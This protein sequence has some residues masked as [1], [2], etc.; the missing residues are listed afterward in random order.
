MVA[1]GRFRQAFDIG[2]IFLFFYGLVF[3]GF[4]IPASKLVWGYLFLVLSKRSLLQHALKNQMLKYCFWVWVIF[5]LHYVLMMIFTD[6]YYT[7]FLRN[8]LWFFVEGVFGAFMLYMYLSKRYETKKMLSMAFVAI[9]IQSIFVVLTFISVPLRDFINTILTITD[10]RGFSSYRMKGFSNFGG[11]G[12]S[13]LQMIGVVYGGVLFLTERVNKRR[14]SLTMMGIFV[15]TVAQ[16]FIGRTGLAAS[17]FLMIIIFLQQAKN[18]KSMLSLIGQVGIGLISIVSLYV[19]LVNVIPDNLK[20]TF[21]DRVIYRSMEVIENYEH[22]GDVSTSSTDHLQTMY[23]LPETEIGILLGTAQW[24][25]NRGNR[26]YVGRMVESDVGYVR[27]IFAVGVIISTVFYSMYLKY[28]RDLLNTEIA[29]YLNILLWCLLFIFIAG[30]LKEPFLVRPTGI[31]K[32][33]F[34][35]YFVF[36]GRGNLDMGRRV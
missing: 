17:I 23:F 14:K 19:V 35:L 9:V 1:T 18:K 21:N 3:N 36:L 27:I 13:Y 6:N 2:L 16:L 7:V 33:L 24:D 34:F 31:I 5:S 15:I 28:I 12:L 10:E 11:A 4:P 29:G 26:E 32:S 8:I 20:N 22:S 25:E 30:E